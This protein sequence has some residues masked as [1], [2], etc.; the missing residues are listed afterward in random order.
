MAPDVM[1]SL[2][3]ALTTLPSRDAATAL[4]RH[5]VD[6]RLAACVNILP[7]CHSIYRWQGKVEAADEV[8]LIIK[9]SKTR[10]LA[11]EQ[12]ICNMHPYELPELLYVPIAGG[13]NAYI[14]WMQ[15][16]TLS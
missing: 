1:P 10:Q 14:Q 15:Q 9:T 12:L 3:I 6:A 7:A 5:L 4:A 13:L 11:L 8:L 16:E 2:M